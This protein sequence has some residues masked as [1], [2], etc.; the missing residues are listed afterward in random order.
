MKRTLIIRDNRDKVPVHVA[1][2]KPGEK[3][4]LFVER[5]QRNLAAMTPGG[6]N[7]VTWQV[8]DGDVV[9]GMIAGSKL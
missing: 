7:G 3:P 1:E 8:I 5:F 9:A 6:L 4:H 2:L